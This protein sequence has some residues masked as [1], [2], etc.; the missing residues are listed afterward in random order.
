MTVMAL[1]WNEK[2]KERKKE[3]KNNLRNC[4]FDARAFTLGP[5]DYLSVLITILYK[6]QWMPTRIDST[7]TMSVKATVYMRALPCDINRNYWQ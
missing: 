3:R 7:L 2:K 1:N 6:G 4:T 5:V